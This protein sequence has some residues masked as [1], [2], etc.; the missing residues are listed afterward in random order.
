LKS[1][2]VRR[3]VAEATTYGKFLA[4]API[5]IVVVIDPELSRHAVEDGAIAT[6]NM[7]LE[8]HSLGLGACWI[9]AYN[10]S[11]EERI[12]EILKIP[13]NKRVLSIISIGYPAESPTKSRKEL[14]EIVFIDS[15]GNKEKL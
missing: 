15:Y 4:N 1:E 7:L 13:R 3:N 2:E 14:D 5:G 10:S 12:K 8:A 9:G 6:M 11:Y